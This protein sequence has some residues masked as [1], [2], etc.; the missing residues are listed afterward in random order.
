MAVSLSETPPPPA[1]VAAVRRFQ[2]AARRRPGAGERIQGIYIAVLV[3]LILTSLVYNAAHSALAQVISPIEV[4]RWGPSLVLLAL[5][6]AAH[7]GTVQGPVVFSVADLG[8]LVLGSPLPRR[9]LVAAPLARALAAAAVSGAAVAGIVVVGLSGRGHTVGAARVI[10]VVGGVALVGILA[11]VAAFAVSI[12][13]RG[14]RVLRLLT[15]PALLAAAALALVGVLAGRTGR[16]IDLWSGPWGWALAAGAGSS[17][18]R[19]LAATAGL[20]V[21]ATLATVVV[22][23]R[24]GSG[25]AERYLRRS[26][27]H[28][29]LQASLTNLNARTARRDL[30]AVGRRSGRRR[31]GDLR[32]LRDR[33]VRWRTRTRSGS[34]PAGGVVSALIWRDALALVERPAIVIQMLMAGVAGT[35]LALLDLGRILGVAAGGVLLYLAANRLLEPLRIENDA[36]RRSRLFLAS[37]PGR[38]Y[39][40]H[41]IIPV[42]LVTGVIALTAA[43]L[44]LAGALHG[45]DSTAAIDLVIAG[46]AIV[47]CAAMSAR[48]GGRL[49][50]EVLMVAM[51]SDPSGGGAVLLAWV[52]VWPAAAAALVALPL[53]SAGTAHAASGSW[54][55]AEVT[56][57]VLL[58]R[59]LARD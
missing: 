14:E 1:T 53:G 44:A 15:P 49:P 36:P 13:R 24:R 33:L 19:Y 4:A 5:L 29:R 32:R 3:T 28:A 22:W 16:Q 45:R 27:G 40:A 9:A 56:V 58:G 21:A 23:Q 37:R 54:A 8:H 6:T 11:T 41:T 55:L 7:W 20:A 31:A 34:A 18:A 48:R 10:D 51:S 17:A 43:A 2:A 59:L 35:A 30:A 46:P 25:E 26:E 38:A 39:V 42:V 50:Q 52:L 57:A 47:G 12:D